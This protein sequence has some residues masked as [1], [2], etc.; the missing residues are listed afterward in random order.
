MNGGARRA[1]ARLALEPNVEAQP[2]RL[3]IAVD[4]VVAGAETHG[5]YIEFVAAV[6]AAVANMLDFRFLIDAWVSLLL[7]TKLETLS[8]MAAMRP[9]IFTSMV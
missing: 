6:V 4:H 1:A 2:R 7:A 3:G 8:S 9:S 5:R